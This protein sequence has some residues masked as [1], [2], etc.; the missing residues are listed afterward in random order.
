MFGVIL[1]LSSPPSNSP[2]S[3]SLEK[4]ESATTISRFTKSAMLSPTLVKKGRAHVLST[5]SSIHNM[6]SI[7]TKF[8]QQGFLKTRKKITKIKK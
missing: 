2:P 8:E 1:Q 6:R 4:D 7:P 5:M 3:H